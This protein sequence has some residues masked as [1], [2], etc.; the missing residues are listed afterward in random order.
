MNDIAN[1][2]A[3]LWLFPMLYIYELGGNDWVTCTKYA[4]VFVLTTFSVVL[5]EIVVI[6]LA[7]HDALIAASNSFVYLLVLVS[8]GTSHIYAALGLSEAPKL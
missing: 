1:G 2:L 8:L 6:G 3:M 5:L 7:F 4:V